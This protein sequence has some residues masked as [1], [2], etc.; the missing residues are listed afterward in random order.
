MRSNWL[1]C[2]V[3]IA[4]MQHRDDA[5]H[6]IEVGERHAAA[7]DQEAPHAGNQRRH[8]RIAIVTRARSEHERIHRKRQVDDAGVDQHVAADGVAGS[9]ID[10]AAMPPSSA[11]S[12]AP[13]AH[14]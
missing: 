8:V 2:S 12:D 6:P 10:A 9:R 7:R 13:F 5:D 14:A 1:R 4:P 3:V 11:A